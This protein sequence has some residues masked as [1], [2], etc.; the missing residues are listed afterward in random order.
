[1][2]D[3]RPRRGPY[4]HAG[5][6][7]LSAP[8]ARLALVTDSAIGPQRSRTEWGAHSRGR[9]CVRRR[10]LKQ[11]TRGRGRYPACES[12]RSQ[13]SSTLCPPGSAK[14]SPAG[15]PPPAR[16]VVASQQ[17]GT[18][19]LSGRRPADPSRR[20]T[21]GRRTVE[22]PA[23][24]HT[25]PAQKLPADPGRRVIPGPASRRT[26]N[27]RA[28]CA[29]LVATGG[30]GLADHPRPGES[31][32]SDRAHC[33]RLV[34]TGRSG[35]ADHPRPGESSRTQ[36]SST[37]CPPGSEQQIRAGGS[38]SCRRASV[39][40]AIERTAPSLVTSESSELG[41]AARPGPEVRRVPS[42]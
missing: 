27:D 15:G 18:L 8:P 26:P 5:P 41:L 13:R 34:A 3:T 2:P 10:P 37:L 7:A 20:I 11:T 19:C 42:G 33:T 16:Q 29:R 31:S 21:A 40:R 24:R 36:R 12:T 14:Q 28:H 4:P 39:L 35:P 38:P 6:L 25:V 17:S 30:S 32:H 22:L 1:V 23:I 9:A